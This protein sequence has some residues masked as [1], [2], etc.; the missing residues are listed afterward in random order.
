M[1][2]LINNQRF[3]LGK[4][5]MG[6]LNPWIYQFGSIGFNEYVPIG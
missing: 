3:N 6:F 2:A 5:P 4:P 1:I